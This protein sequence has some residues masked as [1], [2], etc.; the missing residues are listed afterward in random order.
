MVVVCVGVVGCDGIAAKTP[1]PTTVLDPAGVADD[2]SN[3]LEND[4]QEHATAV[5]CP[6]NE[7]IV[8]GNTFTCTVSVGGQTR[9]VRITVETTQ[10]RF[11]VGPPR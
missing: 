8:V 4:Y 6:S 9:Q 5:R 3:V 11:E 1:P 10:G 7:P 2:V